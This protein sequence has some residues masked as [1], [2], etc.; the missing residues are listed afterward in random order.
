MNND[1]YLLI[2]FRLYQITLCHKVKQISR[3]EA[4]FLILALIK[5]V[6]ELDCLKAT[7]W[8]FRYLIQSYNNNF[9]IL[10]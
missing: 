10:Q 5:N 4:Q 2:C 6:F 3:S 1:L 8:R 7:D 9:L